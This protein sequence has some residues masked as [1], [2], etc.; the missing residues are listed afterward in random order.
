MLWN[1]LYISAKSV[2]IKVNVVLDEIIDWDII[3]FD[4]LREVYVKC[5]TP[6]GKPSFQ[7]DDRWL[8]WLIY[9]HVSDIS[10]DAVLVQVCAHFVNTCKGTTHFQVWLWLWG[11][12][13]YDHA[14]PSLQMQLW[15]W[16]CNSDS[17]TAT[18]VT[19]TNPSPCHSPHCI[20]HLLITHLV[21]FP[22]RTY[23]TVPSHAHLAYVAVIP[24]RVFLRVF[25]L[26]SPLLARLSDCLSAAGLPLQHR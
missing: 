1:W 23:Y 24:S 16:L 22:E 19:F 12:S 15:L 5:P 21:V 9:C 25:S 18:L 6:L 7:K 17:R 26:D 14:T 10:V 8:L 20:S 4:V 11:N 13:S 2:H 3:N